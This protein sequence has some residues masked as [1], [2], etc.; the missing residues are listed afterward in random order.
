MNLQEYIASGK[1]ELYVLDLLP[2]LEK[3]EV[4]DY[5]L[6][7]P[8][9]AAEIE[10]LERGLE[11]YAQLH[12]V[13]PP[14]GTYEG[15]RER[16]RNHPGSSGTPPTPSTTPIAPWLIAGLAVTTMLSIWLF[17]Q[18]AGLENELSTTRTALAELQSSCAEKERAV[19]DATQQLAIYQEKGNRTVTLA[20]SALAP[21]AFATVIYNPATSKTYFSPDDLPPAPAGKQ[22]QLWAL[23]DGAPVDMGVIALDAESGKLLEVPFVESAGAFAITL[24]DAGGKPTPDLSQLYVIGNV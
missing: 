19:F 17:T 2:P 15:I 10:A 9:I 20:G 16:I 22:Y 7:F 5:A 13:P 11:A 14:K 23:V 3:Q 6:R 8:E 4:L 1:L 18:K 21:D 12:A 24:E